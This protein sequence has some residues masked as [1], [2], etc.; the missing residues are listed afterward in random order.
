MPQ[1]NFPFPFVLELAQCRV[2]YP[3]NQKG[4]GKRGSRD[5]SFANCKTGVVTA[6]KQSTTAGTQR[7]TCEYQQLCL[8]F[9]FSHSRTVL[10][11]QPY[12]W[13]T[14][15]VIPVSHT[16]LEDLFLLLLFLC[17]YANS[18]AKEKG[19]HSFPQDIL[20]STK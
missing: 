13:R 11:Y 20:S 4:R 5:I 18:E 8:N 7:H 16:Q 12:C 19:T 14:V 6:P 15:C 1:T 3:Q 17:F 9:Q 2:R 10:C